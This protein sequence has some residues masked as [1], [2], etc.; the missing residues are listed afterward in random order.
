MACETVDYVALPSFKEFDFTAEELRAA[1]V[2]KS[3]ITSEGKI[4]VAVQPAKSRGKSYMK[5][6]LLLVCRILR[7]RL[8]SNSGNYIA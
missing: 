8:F 2:K 3:S 4:A 6:R 5:V 7:N 1:E